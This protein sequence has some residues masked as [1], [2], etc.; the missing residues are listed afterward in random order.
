VRAPLKKAREFHIIFAHKHRSTQ[1]QWSFRSHHHCHPHHHQHRR[2]RCGRHCFIFACR[3]RGF[4]S[5]APPN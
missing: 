2:R 3:L 4:G 1:C 5:V